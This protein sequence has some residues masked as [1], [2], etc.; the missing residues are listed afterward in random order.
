MGDGDVAS[1]GLSGMIR[2][3]NETL[4]IEPSTESG[5]RQLLHVVYPPRGDVLRQISLADDQVYRQPADRGRRKRNIDYDDYGNE[6]TN[7]V[8]APQESVISFIP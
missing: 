5:S 3:N 7:T 1:A 8:N 4:L 2:F 6:I